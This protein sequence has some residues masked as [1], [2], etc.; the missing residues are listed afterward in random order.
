MGE[1]HKTVLNIGCEEELECRG[2]RLTQG[3]WLLSVVLSVVTLGGLQLVFY[4]RNDWRVL[5]MCSQCSLKDAQ[6]VLLHDKFYQVFPAEVKTISLKDSLETYIHQIRPT[7]DFNNQDIGPGG[8]PYLASTEHN[9]SSSYSDNDITYQETNL[10]I[11]EVLEKQ[12]TDHMVYFVHQ[13]VKYIWNNF[14]EDFERLSAFDVDTPCSSFYTDSN[15]INN[16]EQNNKQLVYG[17]NDIDVEVKSYGKLLIEEQA[18]TLRDMVAQNSI[19]TVKRSNVV[20]EI[21]SRELV[22]GDLLL[23]PPNGCMMSCDAVLVAGNCIVNESMLTGESVPVTKT[24]L[25]N[26][27]GC[28]IPYSPD[29][30]KRHTLFCGTQLIQTRYYGGEKVCAIVSRTGF[31]TAKGELVRSILYPKNIGFKFYKDS[32]RFVMVLGCL[33]IVGLLYSIPVL[34]KNN[35]HVKDIIYKALDVITIA[36]PPALPAAMTVGTIYAQSRLKKAGIFCISPQRINMCGKLKLI[37]FDK[38]GTLTEDGLDMLGVVPLQDDHFLPLIQHADEL[39][40]GPFLACMAACHS[41]TIIEGQIT[42][43]PL[44]LKM[45]EATKWILEEQGQDDTTK[46]GNMMP[47][48]VKPTTTETYLQPNTEQ[49]PYEIGIVRQFPFSSNLQRMSVI[50]RTLGAK[51][52]DVY[53]KGAP[54]MIAS[55]CNKQTVPMDFHSTLQ[56]Y[57]QKGLRVIALAWRPLSQKVSWRRIQKLPRSEV[58]NDLTFLGLLILQNMLKPQSTQVINQLREADIRTVMVT[59]DNMLTAISVAR[60]CGMIDPNSSVVLVTASP[61]SST[62]PST[63]EWSYDVPPQNKGMQ[64][65]KGFPKQNLYQNQKLPAPSTNFHFAI[66]GKSFAV[67]KNHFADVMPKIIQ[68]GTVFSRMSPDQ[69][70]QLVEALQELG[71]GVGMCGDGANDCGALKSAHAGISLS[72]AEASVASPFTSSIPNISCVPIVIREGRAALVTSF[73]VFKY[74]A[75]YSIIQFISVMILYWINS[76]LGDFQFLYVDLVITTTVAILMGY[77][78]AYTHLVKKR[79]PGSLV[80]PII[81]ISIILQILVQIIGQ[82]TAYF[83]LFTQDWFEPLHP[84]Q[85]ADENILCPE[86]TVIFVVSSFQYIIVAAAF[87]RGPPYRTPI[88]QNV[89]FLISLIVLC[90]Y[91]AFMLFYPNYLSFLESFFQ[92]YQLGPD[93][94]KFCWII[95]TVIIVNATLTFA[96]E[97]LMGKAF[98]KTF[99]K[100][101][102]KKNALKNIYKRIEKEIMND[103][104]WPPIGQ[105]TTSNCV[106]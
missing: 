9:T 63:I 41:L 78:G 1:Q 17:Y 52:M 6:V 20:S 87:S 33:A 29:V 25:P 65:E 23:I 90:M 84:S 81:L 56:S 93:H 71:Y 86:N 38:T 44:D 2:Y 83:L 50:T 7:K 76:N 106:S 30:H 13:K 58:E 100:P 102:R 62:S 49:L 61:S 10:L 34:L 64:I 15:G 14:K 82:T 99:I 66:N 95:F 59:G 48:V 85:D 54:E 19:V 88:W 24:P 101:C 79:P 47:T 97:W 4:W 77:N 28:N 91:T 67:I 42:G 43:D 57:T 92:V 96:I 37:C 26:P 80:S 94:M 40:R 35:A 98:I 22:P 16:N 21:N 74:M 27:P 12:L 36:V 69:K 46:Y 45:F 18:V 104:D 55:L 11:N 39:P 3:R 73:G 53:V 70:R 51:N 31:E 105:V 32:I 5:F 68:K 60:E 103:P 8:D 72:E 75:L 89:W